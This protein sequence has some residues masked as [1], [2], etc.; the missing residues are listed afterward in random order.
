MCNNTKFSITHV[1][2][3]VYLYLFEVTT[4]HLNIGTRSVIWDRQLIV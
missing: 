2:K 3:R 4:N 1:K